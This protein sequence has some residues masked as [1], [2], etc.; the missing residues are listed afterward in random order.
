MQEII[1]KY[2]EG[3]A[4]KEEQLKLLE[5]MRDKKNQLDFH[6][7]K[8]VWKNSL[9]ENQF[10]GNGEESWNKLQAQLLQKSYNRWQGSWK[11]NQFFKYA[12]IFFFVISLG[13]LAYFLSDF[14]KHTKESFTTVIAENGQISK[15]ELPDGSLV[16]LNSGSKISYCNNFAYNNRDVNLLGEAYFNITKNEDLPLIVNCEDLQVKVLGTRFNVKAYQRSNY[17]GIV[18]EEGA[19]ELL[20]KQI[21]S[22]S[23]K[24]KS[25]ERARYD[26]SNMELNVSNVNT[27]KFTAWKEGV[28]NVYDQSMERVVKRLE[29]RYNQKFEISDEV[30]DFHYTFTIQNESLDEIIKLM[31]KITP[32]K[33]TQRND[34]ITFKM[35]KKKMRET[36]E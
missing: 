24:L 29:T 33:A 20:N 26:K 34:I 6:R 14:S 16:W 19:V 25:G 9:K 8:L 4:S 32:I 30:K 31:E 10:P 27:T 1:T 13:G 28:M 15:V 5:W 22:F 36:D 21:E 23:C 2:L 12:A 35:D 11:I 17:I 3:H 7:Y 18:L